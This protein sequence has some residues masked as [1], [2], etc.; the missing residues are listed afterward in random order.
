MSNSHPFVSGDPPSA[1]AAV[2]GPGTNGEEAGHGGVPAES[3][4]L[5]S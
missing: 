2:A 5:V 1:A 3:L 4:T